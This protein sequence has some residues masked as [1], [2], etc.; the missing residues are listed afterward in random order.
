MNKN[1]FLSYFMTVVF[2]LTV[3]ALIMFSSDIKTI[4]E[5]AENETLQLCKFE[6]DNRTAYNFSVAESFPSKTYCQCNYLLGTGK[7]IVPGQWF[8]LNTTK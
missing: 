5:N 1:E 8:L 3:A 6:C 2:A 7:D 4:K